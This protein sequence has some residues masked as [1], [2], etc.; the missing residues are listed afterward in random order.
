MF[1]ISRTYKDDIIPRRTKWIYTVSG[2]GRDAVYAMVSVFLLTFIQEAGYLSKDPAQYAA[3][4]AVISGLIIGYRVFDAINDPFMGVIIEKVHFKTGKYKPW[5]FLGALTNTIVV[6]ALFLTPAFCDWCHGWGFVAWF[7]VFYL[8]WG[9]TFTMNDIAFCSMLPSL[10]SNEQQ[11]AK[12]TSLLMIFENGGS[13]L[14][15]LL[16]P[17][18]A[19][20][21]ANGGLGT[22]AY[23]IGAL[24][25]GGLFVI[26]QGALFLFCHEHERDLKAEKKADPPHFKDMID[27]LVK[28]KLVRI[29]AIVVFIWFVSLFTLN[30]LLQNV[31]YLSVGYSAGK[32]LMSYFSFVQIAAIV[33]P[34]LFMPRILEKVPKM[35]VFK[36]SISAMIISYFLFFIYGSPIGGQG[37]SLAP[38]INFGDSSLNANSAAYA[39]ILFIITFVMFVANSCTYNVIYLFMENT[40]EY[41]EYRFG[42][43]KEAVIFS[44][45]PFA[46]KMASSIQI[47]ITDAALFSTGFINVSSKINQINDDIEHGVV[48]PEEGAKQLEQL[49]A[50]ASNN[51]GMIYGMRVWCVIVPAVLLIITMFLL[52]KFY[53]LSD[54]D[55]RKMCKEIK[56][57]RA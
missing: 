35:K 1:N 39:S 20:P 29:M 22:K 45:R 23:W 27:I 6:L 38:A 44:L 14:V 13:F 50:D 11:R 3:M 16:I 10:S 43:R 8:L 21:E 46:T 51:L 31:F 5:I 55:Y 30:G 7:A 25:I 28:N 34:M 12:I 32:D 42:Q 17:M 24:I 9:M 19:K 40:V 49:M 36:I 18:M 41:N 47:L 4:F 56:K 48:Q 53:D 37:A 52:V 54:S 33:L 15:S 57:R 2:L 26:G